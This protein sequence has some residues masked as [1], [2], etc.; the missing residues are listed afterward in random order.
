MRV[1]S[2]DYKPI[3]E[4]CFLN[5]GRGAGGYYEDRL[6]ILS[7]E[8]QE[9]PSGLDAVIATADLQ[10][11]ARF[12]KSQSG[13]PRLLGEVLPKILTEVVATIGL[14]N[15][16]RIAVLLAGDFYTVPAL[17]KRG[18]SGDVSS[19]WQSFGRSFGAVAGVAGNHDTFGPNQETR[20][21]FPKQLRFLDGDRTSIEGIRVAGIGGIIGNPTR[22]QRR[23]EQEYLE[24]LESL[25][26]EPL[27]VLVMHD[28]PDAPSCGFKGSSAVR[29][30]IERYQPPLVVRGHSHWPDPLVELASGVQVL[31]VDARA[32]VLRAVDRTQANP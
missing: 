17:D 7:A 25:L 28:G 18:G 19:V 20:P 27:D 11:R 2:I 14:S 1:V 23:T 21:R 10:G 31:N 32:V 12:Q 6:P 8:L 29:E 4:V 9:L 13:P 5:A 22:L 3:A 26:L 15:P 24:V 16:D 30:V